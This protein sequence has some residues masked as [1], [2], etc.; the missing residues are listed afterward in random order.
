MGFSSGGRG[1]VVS[2]HDTDI[3][4]NRA[5]LNSA[6]FRFFFAIF[7]SFFRCPLL[8]PLEET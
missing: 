2:I 6:T 5:K 3:V 7:Q 4:D 1:A 8:S